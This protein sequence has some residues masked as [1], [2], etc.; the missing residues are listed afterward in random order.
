MGYT[1]DWLYYLTFG[2]AVIGVLCVFH[3][4]HY[5]E[6]EDQFG[7]LASHAVRTTCSRCGKTM[8]T[9]D[10]KGV[11]HHVERLCDQCANPR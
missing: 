6:T 4:V 7:D 1:L 9:L 10:A 5:T 2:V 8:Y 11:I 3:A